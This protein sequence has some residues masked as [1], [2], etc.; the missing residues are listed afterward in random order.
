MLPVVKAAYHPILVFAFSV[1]S[2]PSFDLLVLFLAAAFS[3][4]DHAL[5]LVSWL[6]A[7]F[8]LACL[9]LRG[10][11]SMTKKIHV[12]KETQVGCVYG[13][14][15]RALGIAIF[16]FSLGALKVRFRRPR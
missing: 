15:S 7:F 3:S 1:F 8:F 14:C 13:R 4:L 9:A 16:F 10:G 2:S 5:A 11:A 6:V 12:S